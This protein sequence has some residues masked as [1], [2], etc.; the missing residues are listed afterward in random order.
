MPIETKQLFTIDAINLVTG[1][2]GQ[3]K[4]A[5]HLSL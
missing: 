5:Q 2:S 1:S 4:A 3:T